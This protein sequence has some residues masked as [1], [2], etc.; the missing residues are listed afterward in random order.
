M[1]IKKI[2]TIEEEL[3]RNKEDLVDLERYIKEF[4]FFLP[5]AVCSANPLEVII[6]INKA[7]TVLT[8][9]HPTEITGGL[10]ETLFLEKKE[11][12]EFLGE[13]QKKERII[14]GE[15]TLISKE[16]KEIPVSVSLSTRKDEEGNF[17]GYFLAFSN[18]AGIKK[19]REELEKKVEE[20]TKKLEQSK[21]AMINMLEDVEEARRKAEEEKN[22]VLA[23]QKIRE[24]ELEE[25]EMRTKELEEAKSALVNMLEDVDVARGRAEEE[26]N[27]TSAIIINLTDGLLV[28]DEKDRLSLVNPRAED[29]F[30][31]RSEEITGQPISELIK[32]PNLEPLITLLAKETKGVSRKELKIRGKLTLEVS[33]VPMLRE[34]EGLGT[35]II[36]HDV[37]REK[38]IERMKTEFVSLAAHQL[39]TPLSAIKW[40]LRMLLDGDLGMLTEEQKEF[41]EKSYQSNERMISLINDLLDV[42]R[43]EEGRYVFKPVLVNLEDI[44]QFVVN[45]YKEG[46]EKK[47]LKLK[48]KKPITKLPKVEVD[49]E[50][51]RLVIQNFLE[52]AINYTP[53]GGEIVISLKY[54]KDK[55]EIEFKIQ[56]TGVG[57]PEDQKD[58]VF[59]KFFRGANV[60][61]MSTEGSGLGLFISKNI[62]EAHG[63]RAWFE[64]KEN[65]GSSFYFTLPVGKEFEE[66]LKEF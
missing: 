10:L 33:T 22:K 23:I 8:G 50:K 36:L 27:K 42:T 12:K 26:K 43:I 3:K 54:Y 39:R 28:F 4:S 62:I 49:V 21:T 60:I 63:G 18:I 35:L 53:A 30:A 58:R 14:A 1:V 44:V 61:R 34:E 41:V 7:F 29:F 64:S 24:A 20:R 57:V 38:T 40:T 16:K 65:Q 5:L 25:L 55:K 45:P 59:T 52:N 32:F 11:M 15:L 19:S 9:Y 51:I 37:T 2:S 56:D 48:F 47:H 13:A 6:D 17:I 66:F 31:I 46:V